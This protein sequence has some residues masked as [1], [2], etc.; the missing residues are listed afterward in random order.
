MECTKVIWKYS[1]K[2]YIESSVSNTYYVPKYC[3]ILAS[4]AT[5]MVH[6]LGKHWEVMSNI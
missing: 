4:I 5:G 2:K 6:V 1:K 3:V